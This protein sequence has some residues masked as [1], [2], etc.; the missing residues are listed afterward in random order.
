M[1]TRKVRTRVLL[2]CWRHYGYI[3]VPQKK[4][5]HILG[6]AT[7]WRKCFVV[8]P[9]TEISD[10]LTKHQWLTKSV[11][12]KGLP[13]CITSQT[14]PSDESVLTSFEER[15]CDF[16]AYQ[17][18]KPYGGR[19]P[20][21]PSA[22]S[23]LLQ[24]VLASVWPLAPDYWHLRSSHMTPQP[25]VEC[26][27]RRN[28]ENYISH[29]QPLYILHTNMALGLF[30][31]S[32]YVGDG[33]PPVE[34]SPLHLSLFKHTFDQILPFGGS[35][36]FGPYTLAHTLFIL[37]KKNVFPENLYTHGLIQ[38]FSQA[39]AEAVQNE[40]KLDRDL[41]YPLATQGIITNGKK[42]T[43]VCF[44]LNTLDLQKDSSST[45]HNIFWAGPSLDLYEEVNAGKGLVNFN[46]D[47][48]ELVV[49]FLLH[50]P[51]RK[52]LRQWGGG[53]RA[54]PRYK[55]YTDAQELSPNGSIQ[56]TQHA[57]E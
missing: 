30:S 7:I 26:Y 11:L 14:L 34:Y 17:I 38:L 51:I 20:L 39:A 53:S 54:M 45:K 19:G 29:T 32:D 25:N 56:E 55:M 33:L 37:D 31:A 10:P 6:P 8:Q 13:E 24:S 40:F 12:I 46:R 21:S 36:R 49:K 57:K 43:F 27:W 41:L 52:R 4:P 48:A 3:H 2:G 50:Q 47:C 5:P 18:R 9:F 23:G 35:R 16:L 42:F 28:G 1:W 44:Q 15:A 22:V